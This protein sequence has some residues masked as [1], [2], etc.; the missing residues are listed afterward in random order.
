MQII[1]RIALAS[2]AALLLA[3]CAKKDQ[4]A[5]DSAAA[6]A[7][8]PAP[9][10]APA[11]TL[12]LTDV[13]GKWQFRSVPESGP[14]TAAT[15]YVV[16]ATADGAGSEI[17]FPGGLKVPAQVMVHGDTL[18]VTTAGFT[19]QRKKGAKVNKTE[20]SAKMQDGKLVGT[21]VAYYATAGADSVVRF[22]AE[23][24]KMP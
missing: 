1:S 18:M 2:S 24:T 3:G 23:G 6:A 15:T 7:A 5:A 8:T 9:A 21:M 20:T 19:S 12:A 22:R 11:P 13:A 4:A 14:D 10:P 17:T 16:T